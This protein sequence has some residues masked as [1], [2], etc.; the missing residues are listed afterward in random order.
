MREMRYFLLESSR[1]AR[2]GKAWRASPVAPLP[3]GMTARFTVMEDKV[4][5]WRAMTGF[6]DLDAQ[7]G[8]LTATAIVQEPVLSFSAQ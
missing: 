8:N 7:I 2:S 3:I 6:S 5:V 4:I 1:C